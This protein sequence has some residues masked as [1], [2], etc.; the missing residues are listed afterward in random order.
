[1]FKITAGKSLALCLFAFAASLILDFQGYTRLGNY[2]F[3]T[4]FILMPVTIFLGAV[5]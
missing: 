2:V 4:V 3:Y 5:K 1:M